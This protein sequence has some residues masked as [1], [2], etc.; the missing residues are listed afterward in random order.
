MATYYVWSG[1]TGTNLGTSWT[2]AWVSVASLPAPMAAGDIVK[3]HTGSTSTHSETLSANITIQGPASNNAA[4]VIGVDKDNSD[5]YTESA[6][7]N[8]IT[9]TAADIIIDGSL[10]VYGIHFL[11]DDRMNLIAGDSNELGYY[12]D[13][14]FDCQKDFLSINNV[15]ARYIDCDFVFGTTGWMSNGTLPRNTEIIGGTWTGSRSTVLTVQAGMITLIG[16]DMSG[17]TGGNIVGFSAPTGRVDFIGCDVPSSVIS[18]TLYGIVNLY[19]TSTTAQNDQWRNEHLTGLGGDIALSKTVYKDSGGTYDGTTN[20]SFAVT[21]KAVNDFYNPLYTEWNTGY[22]EADSGTETTWTVYI[23]NVTADIYD[24]DV[25]LEVEYY[26]NSA[27]TLKEVATNRM[28]GPLDT[29]ALATDDTV[30]TWTGITEFAQKLSVTAT[31]AKDGMY[32]WR[33][34]S[35]YSTSSVYV[36]TKID[37]VQA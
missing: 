22:V 16:V 27:D 18:S 4:L 33:V 26:K 32:R 3:I 13:C 1:A 34:A 5:A 11:S 12:Q 9:D 7:N 35:S 24:D 10:A 31:V 30:S 29:P 25:W 8:I 23:A 15:T 6:T 28:V 21:A 2:D 20:Y 36:D 14:R 37:V 17:C 19:G